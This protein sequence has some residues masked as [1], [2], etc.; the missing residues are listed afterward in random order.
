MLL[1]EGWLTRSLTGSSI[2]QFLLSYWISQSPSSWAYSLNQS[3]HQ[4]LALSSSQ[5]RLNGFLNSHQSKVG[6]NQSLH[7]QLL[8]DQSLN[9]S[10][11]AGLTDSVAS[12]MLPSINFSLNPSIHARSIHQS[13]LRLRNYIYNICTHPSLLKWGITAPLFLPLNRATT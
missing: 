1:D 12:S 2:N 13:I 9:Q 8:L 3:F 6:M 7:Q 11:K 4:S 10:I 5:F